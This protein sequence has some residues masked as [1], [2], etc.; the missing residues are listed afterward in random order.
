V[1]LVEKPFDSN[2]LIDLVEAEL[3]LSGRKLPVS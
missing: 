2:E 1:T 3:V